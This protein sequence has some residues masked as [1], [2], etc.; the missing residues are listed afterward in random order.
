MKLPFC[1]QSFFCK[2]TFI[3]VKNGYAIYKGPTRPEVQGIHLKAESITLSPIGTSLR[4]RQQVLK[5]T[6]KLHYIISVQSHDLCIHWIYILCTTGPNCRFYFV[7]I[8]T[9][10]KRDLK[11]FFLAHKQNSVIQITFIMK[12]RIWNKSH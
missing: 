9:V 6:V 7:K 1:T 5:S 12:T 2:F 3:H 8:N 10:Q 11:L 4:K